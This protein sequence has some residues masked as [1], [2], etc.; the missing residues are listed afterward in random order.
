MVLIKNNGKKLSRKFHLQKDARRPRNYDGYGYVYFFRYDSASEQN[1]LVFYTV[2]ARSGKDISPNSISDDAFVC[3]ISCD[4]CVTTAENIRK[5][6]GD[7]IFEDTIPQ[8]RR[9]PGI[10]GYFE[11]IVNHNT[12]ARRVHP[13]ARRIIF[14]PDKHSEACDDP[15]PP[16]PIIKARVTSTR[17]LKPID[18]IVQRP[19]GGFT[20]RPI[21]EM[22]AECLFGRF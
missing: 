6:V 16:K 14:V 5:M 21:E 4:N 12:T 17:P 15:N 8:G 10:F 1:P 19:I 20:I 11:E 13:F 9:G 3:A 18:K 2:A 7:P 22:V